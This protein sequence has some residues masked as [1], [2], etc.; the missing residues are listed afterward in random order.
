LTV[1]AR[2]P[3]GKYPD[4][5]AYA[6][7]VN[8]LYV[9][10]ETGKTDTVID[11][12]TNKRI[13]TIP[14]GGTVGNTQYDSVSKHIFVNV[15]GANELAEIDPQN[16]IVVQKISVPAAKGNHGLLIE[17]AL[18]LAFIACE[19]NDKLLVMNLR[20]K[21]V[22]AQFDVGK[23]PDV[24]AFDKNLGLLY[25]AS[26]AGTVSVFKVTSQR[27]S[28]LGDQQIGANA[29]TVAVDPATHE[30]YFPLKEAGGRPVL[31]VM[32]PSS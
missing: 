3:G 7:E 32:Q 26:E 31:R 18:R 21:Q 23:D 9:S 28:K 5:L 17:P 25:V 14:L 20:S 11:T 29:H 22:V 24:L 16:D 10:D 8:K 1:T 27:V 2:I 13:A 6:P 15:Q 4:G 12:G 30:V 19:G